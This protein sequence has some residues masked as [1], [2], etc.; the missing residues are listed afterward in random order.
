MQGITKNKP[1]PGKSHGPRGIRKLSSKFLLIRFVTE[2]K[3]RT[4]TNL[5]RM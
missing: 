5:Q 4:S 2:A 3:E 1:G